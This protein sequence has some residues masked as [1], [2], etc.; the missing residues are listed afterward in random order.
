MPTGPPR[1]AV[2]DKSG[3]RKV[4][5][6]PPHLMRSSPRPRPLITRRSGPSNWRPR[7]AGQLISASHPEPS[8]HPDPGRPWV[9]R[10]G[11]V[12]GRGEA[13]A[14]PS[15]DSQV[16]GG[17]VSG[18][19]LCIWRSVL[20]GV[21][22]LL[23][24]TRGGPETC[25]ALCWAWGARDLKPESPAGWVWGCSGALCCECLARLGTASTCS[26][27]GPEPWAGVRGRN[28]GLHPL[29]G[30]TQVP[31]SA[32]VELVQSGLVQFQGAP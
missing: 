28:W 14:G 30:R 25:Q 24:R 17:S 2:S 1:H 6:W 18:G 9:C 15:P 21:G 32:T 19:L 3:F 16:K 5:T 22:S 29:Q 10:E 27:P 7:E 31:G 13:Q 26:L 20:G 12:L 8:G 4:L 11:G 23:L